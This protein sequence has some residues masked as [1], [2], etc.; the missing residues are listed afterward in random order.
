MHAS[1][2]AGNG[3]TLHDGMVFKK[4]Q[5]HYVVEADGKTI[6]CSISSRLRKEL[7]YPTS[8]PFSGTLRRVRSV[9]DIREVDPVAVGDMVCFVDAGN[10]TGM[11]VEVLPRKNKLVRSAAGGKAREQVIVANVDQVVPV[12]AAAQPAPKWELLDRYLVAAEAADMP[13]LICITKIDLVEPAELLEQLRPYR[14]IGYPVLLT[15]ASTGEGIE[16]FKQALAGRVSVFAG[17]SGVGKTT[18]LNYVQPGLGLRVNEVSSQTGKGKHTT[19]SLEMFALDFGGSVVDTPGMRSF[20]LWD[21]DGSD[22]AGLF[23]EMRPYLG[24]CRFG[25]SCGHR[26][27]PGCAIKEAVATG[28]IDAR[29]YQSFLRLKG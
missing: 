23:R 29:R 16:T 22:L 13:A 5:G 17:K 6:V 18:L 8:S 4:S 27:E 1:D 9:E 10:D 25:A 2:T 14:A 26:H 15:S 28:A 3:H 24:R 7:I 21:V 19:T 11:I 20:G 12:F